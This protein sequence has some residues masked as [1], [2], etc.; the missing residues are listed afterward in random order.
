MIAFLPCPLPDIGSG[1]DSGGRRDH[2]VT[3]SREPHDDRDEP[4]GGHRSAAGPARDGVAIRSTGPRPPYHPGGGDLGH[5]DSRRAP[6]ACRRTAAG[7]RWWRQR[8]GVER[9]H[10][11]TL[12]ALISL[13]G[14]V[15]TG[16]A[17]RLTGSGL[18][19]TDWP[20]CEQ[21]R[22]VAPLELHPS[23]WSS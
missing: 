6:E 14:I 22:L 15:I 12:V 3:P 17:V 4:R 19:C 13:V 5:D 2:P 18:G 1:G 20:N 10:R 7:G 8:L 16:A 11:I 21:G 23:R 9:Y